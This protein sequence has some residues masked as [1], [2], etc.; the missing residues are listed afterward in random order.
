[1]SLGWDIYF[2]GACVAFVW[3]L[4]IVQENNRIDI[5]GTLFCLLLAA[6]SWV[7]VLALW[8]GQNIKHNRGK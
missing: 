1:M 5:A 6:M 2:F 3:T 7:G 4:T 8:V